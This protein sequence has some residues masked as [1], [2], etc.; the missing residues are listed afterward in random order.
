[1]LVSQDRS[2]R[3]SFSDRVLIKCWFI[4]WQVWSGRPQFPTWHWSHFTPIVFGLQGQVPSVPQDRFAL[5]KELQLQ[6]RQPVKR[7]A[8]IQRQSKYKTWHMVHK[9][10]YRGALGRNYLF[11]ELL[12]IMNSKEW[13]SEERVRRAARAIIVGKTRITHPT[14]NSIDTRALPCLVV[15]NGTQGSIHVAITTW[16]N[17]TSSENIPA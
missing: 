2:P 14:P 10:F 7:H 17:I 11:I 5:P 16:K 9:R 1:M 6:G 15:A 12:N 13:T 4:P 3:T 8:D